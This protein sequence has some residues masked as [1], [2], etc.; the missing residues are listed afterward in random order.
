[1][2]CPPE[3]AP[4]EEWKGECIIMSCFR[5]FWPPPP[6]LFLVEERWKNINTA[7]NMPP[8]PPTSYHLLNW[9]MEDGQA[10]VR[11]IWTRPS[12]ILKYQDD[13]TSNILPSS[14]MHSKFNLKPCTESSSIHAEQFWLRTL[15]KYNYRLGLTG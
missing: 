5:N 9:F 13:M 10:W 3:I 2:S 6:L 15:F 11:G 14:K 7:L 12:A 1:M 8:P 4:H